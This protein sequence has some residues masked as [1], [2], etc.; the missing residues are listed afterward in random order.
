MILENKKL[1]NLC[2]KRKVRVQKDTYFHLAEEFVLLESVFR[3]DNFLDMFLLLVDMVFY[4]LYVV[5]QI[6]QQEPSPM[7]VFGMMKTYQLWIDWF[8]YQDLLFKVTEWKLIVKSVGGPWIATNDPT[9]H[10]YV[11]ADA[12]E[13][14]SHATN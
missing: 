11:Y 6:I 7:F 3:M 13:R 12:M 10:V 5:A 4:P 1:K 8:R 14:M 2:R 9:Y